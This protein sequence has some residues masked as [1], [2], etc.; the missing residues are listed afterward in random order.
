MKNEKIAK[1]LKESRKRNRLSVGDVVTRLADHS[2]KV[3]EKTVYGWRAV[4]RSPMPTLF[5]CFVKF[6]ASTTFWEPSDIRKMNRCRSQ[7]SNRI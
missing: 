5:F 6:T 2:C 7:P 3:A 1:V 4:R